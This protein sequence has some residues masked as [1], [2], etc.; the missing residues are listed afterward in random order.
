[1]DSLQGVL[2]GTYDAF[3]THFNNAGSAL[4]FSTY[5]GGS[6]DDFGVNVVR[7]ASGSIYLSGET[8]SFDF[9]LMNSLQGS[10]AGGKDIFVAKFDSAPAC[11]C[12]CHADPSCDGVTNVLDVVQSVNVAFRG[13]AAQTD[14]GCPNEQTDVNCDDVTNV[15]DVVRVVNVAFRGAD[16]VVEFCDACAP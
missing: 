14:A 16:P 3:I 8:E 2:K 15:L 1:V 12:P 4:I 11:T 7:D 9:P 6:G 5:W 10:K 13:Q